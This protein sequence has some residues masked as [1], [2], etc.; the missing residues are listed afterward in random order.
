MSTNFNYQ[1]LAIKFAL[2]WLWKG[3]GVGEKLLLASPTGTGK[4]YVLLGLQRRIRESGLQALIVTPSPQ[5]AL[6]MAAKA[7]GGEPEELGIFTALRLRNLAIAGEAP[8]ADVLLFDEAHH[9]AA[10][11]W[12]ML[13][14]CFGCPAI[15]VTATPY[16]GTPK[17]TAGFRETWGDPT[18]IITIPEAIQRGVWSL[19]ICRTV[20]LVD[21][22]VVTVN[23]G[24]FAVTSIESETRTRLD[25]AANV[26]LP[27]FDGQLWDRPT[28]VCVPSVALAYDFACAARRLFTDAAFYVVTGETSQNDRN[29]VFGRL[30]HSETAIIQ[31]GVVSEGVDLP[32][33]R[34]LDLHP[35]LSPVEWLQQFG[36][37]TRPVGHGEPPPEYICTNRNLMRHAYL[38]EG[39]L[40]S[41]AIRG[42]ERAFGSP[43]KRAGMRAIGLECLGRFKAAELPLSD[44]ITGSMYLL[45]SP[46]GRFT[47]QFACLLHPS[48]AEP[49]WATRSNEKTDDPMKPVYGRWKRCDP[50]A[51]VSGFA[52]VPPSQC[53]EKMAAW[54][55]R[56]A[57][58]RGLDPDAEVSR[59]N[60]AA[61]PILTDLREK[62]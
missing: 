9:A 40:P 3:R 39:A 36:R 13:D 32:I 41:E 30:R 50:P 22:D 23:N 48:R 26:L 10:A 33:R 45:S 42:A 1:K 49:I 61:L 38:L 31:I 52:S 7:G 4:S 51:D 55:K 5:I 25:D 47:R 43:S 37:I 17:S 44:S 53:T 12:E 54:W 59:K 58:R 8:R 27:Y 6:D 35:M 14:L 20:P 34:I 2:D 46:E 57:A 60:F 19:P 62:L 56:D 29:I 21:D 11:T 24:Q 18:W 28:M 15:G 16:R